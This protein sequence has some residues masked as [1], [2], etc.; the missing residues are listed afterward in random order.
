MEQEIADERKR[1]FFYASASCS[2]KLTLTRDNSVCYS[3]STISPLFTMEQ[4]QTH[5][6]YGLPGI[7]TPA[8]VAG[9]DR[10]A[11]TIH[12]RASGEWKR[13]DDLIAGA[14]ILARGDIN[15][16]G[17]VRYISDKFTDLDVVPTGDLSTLI[18]V[19]RKA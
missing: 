14:N 4:Q 8:S 17:L 3:I 11:D 1:F 9:W 15:V 12:T 16:D 19:R 5:E 13:Y 7:A 2:V 6:K 10:I 18:Q